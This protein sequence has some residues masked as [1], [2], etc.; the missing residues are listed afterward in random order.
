MVHCVHDAALPVY[1]YHLSKSSS[2]S[3]SFLKKQTFLY[4]Q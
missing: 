4:E 3:V 2:M 1:S